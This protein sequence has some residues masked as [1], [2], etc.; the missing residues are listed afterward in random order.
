M[1]Q[2]MW[3]EVLFSKLHERQLLDTLGQ[4]LR[5]VLPS[6]F[7]ICC[8]VA[9]RMVHVAAGS[10]AHANELRV[11]RYCHPGVS[12]A[13]LVLAW[14]TAGFVK[15]MTVCRRLSDHRFRCR[16]RSL[17]VRRQ[18]S[19]QLWLGCGHQSPRCQLQPA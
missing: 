4:L 1:L 6:S 14:H 5:R 7:V 11:A 15:L 19:V 17:A 10:A 12:T 9:V 3:S 13:T 16:H 18:S 2:C 8:S